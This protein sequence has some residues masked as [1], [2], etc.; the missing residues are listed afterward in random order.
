MS[1]ASRQMSRYERARDAV[2][3]ARAAAVALA[4]RIGG[5][6]QVAPQ[7]QQD[8]RTDRLTASVVYNDDIVNYIYGFSRADETTREKIKAAANTR[9]FRSRTL[10]RLRNRKQQHDWEQRN[11]RR[12]TI[13]LSPIEEGVLGM[14][15]NSDLNQFKFMTE[16]EK[17]TVLEMLSPEAEKWLWN[18]YSKEDNPDALVKTL[19]FAQL[20]SGALQREDL[21]FYPSPN[22]KEPKKA[23]GEI[24][25]DFLG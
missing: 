4:R 17:K 15:P 13:H 23:N 6:R 25:F 9:N 10:N 7:Q 1:G 18:F 20:R 2:D 3:A 24:A 19:A 11:R 8:E 21:P 5:R 14:I 22:M 16:E 12:Q